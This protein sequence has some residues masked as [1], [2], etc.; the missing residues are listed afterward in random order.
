MGDEVDASKAQMLQNIRMRVAELKA[1]E[2]LQLYHDT[3]NKIIGLLR[4][5]E[6]ID[7]GIPTDPIEL[8]DRLKS[9]I[10]ELNHLFGAK[11]SLRAKVHA[12]VDEVFDR[13]GLP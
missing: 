5:R 1:D 9:I 11:D 3:S 12:T 13:N 10:H 2:L 6:P 7:E 4:D 8:K